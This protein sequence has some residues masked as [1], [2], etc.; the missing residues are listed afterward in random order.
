M[1]VN[2][3][4][5]MRSSKT[6]TVYVSYFKFMSIFKFVFKGI[7]KVYEDINLA[8]NVRDWYRFLYKGKLNSSRLVKR[9]KMPKS[10]NYIDSKSKVIE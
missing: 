1:E 10:F 9:K 2:E 6:L 7:L 8:D 5:R 3:G 4:L